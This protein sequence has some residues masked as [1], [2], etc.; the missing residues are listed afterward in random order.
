VLSKLQNANEIAVRKRLVKGEKPFLFEEELLKLSTTT[1][2]FKNHPIFEVNQAVWQLYQFPDQTD[3]FYL[4]KKAILQEHKRLSDDQRQ[5]I[6]FHLINYAIYRLNNKDL[7]FLHEVNELYKIADQQ[8]L[9]LY[10]K[11]ITHAT[12]LNVATTDVRRNFYQ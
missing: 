9:L 4:I 2:P 10:Q 5:A 8:N 7:P 11:Q 12:F 3:A 6:L 1:A